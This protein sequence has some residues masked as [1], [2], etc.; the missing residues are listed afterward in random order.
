MRGALARLILAT[1]VWAGTAAPGAP[2]FLQAADRPDAAGAKGAPSGNRST[3]I[4]WAGGGFRAFTVDIGLTAGLLAANARRD[5]VAPL[6]AETKFLDRFGIL[7]SNSGSTWFFTELA[8]S[9]R[10]R[11]MVERMAASPEK[12]G[13][14][15][16]HDWMQGWIA[17]GTDR[18]A[19]SQSEDSVEA[20]R[21]RSGHTDDDAH[22][23]SDFAIL[24]SIRE[25]SFFWR[26]GLSWN[27]FVHLLLK[28]TS[29]VDSLNYMG[30]PVPAWLE[31]KVWMSVHSVVA[32]TPEKEA[33]L[34][35]SKGKV[36]RYHRVGEAAVPVYIPAKHSIVLGSGR[37]AAAPYPYFAANSGVHATS[38]HY[39]GSAWF[40]LRELH[41]QTAALEQL[42]RRIE[43]RSGALPVSGVASA[44][45]AVAG[46]M[47]LSSQITSAVSNLDAQLTPWAALALEG[48]DMF[49]R[50]TACFHDL[51]EKGVSRGRLRVCARSGVAG[52]VDGGYTD[53]SGVAQAVS[54]G[55][56]EVVMVVNDLISV[57]ALFQR[58]KGST[59]TLGIPRLH[60]PIFAEWYSDALY[61]DMADLH[62]PEPYQH[63][64]RFMVASA[65]GTT[66]RNDLFGIAEGHKVTLRIVYV[67]TH[68]LIG[69]LSDYKD[70]C[71]L[72]EEM[73]GCMLS[74]KNAHILDEWFLRHL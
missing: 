4:A 15:F 13:A 50:G 67:R 56:T 60:L 21:N 27:D 72:A 1:G 14:E 47:C 23:M 26:R 46:G 58:E 63:V 43:S 29:G 35:S 70:Y 9:W 25:V 37:A 40:G 68:L 31:G 7:S 44:S 39:T 55:A 2:R 73:M 45:S 24:Q 11:H 20:A 19:K 59:E 12:A 42:G 33:Q 64:Q 17:L 10:F 54:A 22:A 71:G 66:V 53:G 16:W 65:N 8:F 48:S 62:I 18:V 34:S 5:R 52:V 69:A 28:K 38:L 36:V 49:S 30:D 3:A 61:Q 6:F 51:E 57:S 74:D 41:E 32:G